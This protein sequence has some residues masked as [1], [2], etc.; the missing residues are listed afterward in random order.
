MNKTQWSPTETQASPAHRESAAIRNE[1][2]RILFHQHSWM[3]HDGLYACDW[4][5]DVRAKIR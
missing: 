2:K 4:A 5:V 1:W 3:A